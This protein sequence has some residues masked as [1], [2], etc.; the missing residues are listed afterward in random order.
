MESILRTIREIHERDSSKAKEQDNLA[1]APVHANKRRADAAPNQ[2]MVVF[3]CPHCGWLYQATQ[4]RPA[5]KVS[6]CFN[7]KGCTEEVHS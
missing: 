7:C 6:G 4:I 5:D 2:I 3:L 1:S